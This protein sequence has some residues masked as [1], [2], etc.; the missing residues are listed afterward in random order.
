M[1]MRNHACWCGIC[2]G[3]GVLSLCAVG[4][5][6]LRRRNLQKARAKVN[7]DLAAHRKGRQA[8]EFV[9]LA[10]VRQQSAQ[11]LPQR[12]FAWGSRLEAHSTLIM[13]I[14]SVAGSKYG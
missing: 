6:I 10:S 12:A 11:Q 14:M 13:M 1:Y 4:A 3:C 7:A 5:L 8:G 9:R 2:D